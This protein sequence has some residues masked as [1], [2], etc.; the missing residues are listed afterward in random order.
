MRKINE[1]LDKQRSLRIKSEGLGIFPRGRQL[2][3]LHKA[4]VLFPESGMELHF[5]KGNYK[6]NPPCQMRMA[7]VKCLHPVS[8]LSGCSMWALTHRC[9]LWALRERTEGRKQPY[10]FSVLTGF[11]KVLQRLAKEG[12]PPHFCTQLCPKIEALRSCFSV[13]DGLQSSDG[14]WNS[15]AKPVFHLLMIAVE[16]F[17]T[18]TEELTNNTGSTASL[19]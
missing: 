17:P 19:P 12:P 6:R 4:W 11:Y 16:A 18:K 14:L 13:T 7:D 15:C 3:H 5:Q 8:T 9:S 2:V 10:F 1:D